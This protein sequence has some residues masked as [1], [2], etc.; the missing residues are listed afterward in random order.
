M[1][2]VSGSFDFCT[3][4]VKLQYYIAFYYLWLACWQNKHS[5]QFTAASSDIR[6]AGRP[7]DSV[8]LLMFV[9]SA[10]CSSLSSITS[11]TDARLFLLAAFV[12]QNYFQLIS[13]LSSENTIYSSS[14]SKTLSFLILEALQNDL[15]PSS[16]PFLVVSAISFWQITHN[17]K[18]VESFSCLEGLSFVG[19]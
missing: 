7:D 19:L 10:V 1:L 16:D 6:V 17:S 12:P 15:I 2:S 18:L 3:Y 13:I 14:R 11:W 8:L 5:S 9:V 4:I